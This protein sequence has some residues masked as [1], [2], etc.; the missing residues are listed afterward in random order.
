[1]PPKPT[2][3]SAA[4][5][6]RAGRSD[7]L[8]SSTPT[9]LTPT[10]PF[11][12][13][14]LVTALF[15]FL[16]FFLSHARA[17]DTATI[18]GTVSNRATGNLL[19]GVRVEVSQLG[20]A[21]YTDQTGRYVLA[22]LPAGT[23]E[24]A[25]S[26]LGLD[27]SR[28]SV[29][30]LA[31]GR[32]E[33]NFELT[34]GIYQMDA[35]K[36][37][38][39]REGA[40]AAL[41]AQRNA[42]N[43]KNVVAMDSFGNLPNMS[44][45][46]VVMRLPGTAGFPSDEGLYGNF[47]IRGTNSALNSVTIDGA[48]SPGVSFQRGFGQRLF[49]I[50]GTMFESLEL[51]KGHTPDKGADS[52]SGT[53]NMKTRSPLSM[54]EKRRTTYSVTARW[55]PPFLEQT[56]ERERH[57]AHHLLT[58]A[59]QQIFDVFGGE[60]NLA[61]ALNLFTSEN[62]VSGAST[63]YDYQNTQNP[64]AFIWD[65][66]TRNNYNNRKQDSISLRTDYRWSPKT[67]FWVTL[68]GNNNFE[69]HNRSWEVRAFSDSAAAVP[70]ATTGIVPGAFS[71]Q[72]TVVRPVAGAVIDV[73][74]IG[75]RNFYVRTRQFDFNAEHG[76]RNWQIDY[77]AGIGRTNLNNGD[78]EGGTLT[79]RLAGVGWII[80]RTRSD[81]TP[82]F[83]QNGGPDFLNGA[84]YR[85]TANGLLNVNTQRDQQL[86]QF[87]LNARYQLPVS[88]PNYLKAG[89]SWREQRYG[90]WAKDDHRWSYIG[91]APLPTDPTIGSYH[92]RETGQ[93]LPLWQAT[94]VI[95]RRR[96][97]APAL[98]REDLYY[99][100]SQKFSA[101][102]GLTETAQAAYLMAQGKLGREGWLARSGYLGG[103]RFE[104]T[105]VDTWGWVRSRRL[106][107]AAQ[108]VADPVGAALLDYGNNYRADRRSYRQP[109]PS[110]HAF[111]DV[112][113]NLKFRTAFSTSFGRAGFD[114][115]V[116]AETPQREREHRVGQQSRNSSPD[117]EELGRRPRVLLRA[118]RA[119]LTLVV[120]QGNTRLHHRQ[121]GGARHPE[122]RR[123]WVQ[124]R[125]CRLVRT[126]HDQRRQRDRPGLGVRIPAAVHV[127]ARP[128]EGALRAFQLYVD[129]H[130]RHVQRHDLPDA[131]RN[132]GVHPA[133]GQRAT[134]LEL[135][136]VQH[137]APL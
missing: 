68:L 22:G 1:M 106:T 30:V 81:L 82:R 93:N 37:A 62:V 59:H 2:R 74:N 115:F 36:V 38:G 133:H 58:L 127:S 51:I 113:S 109:F 102:Q 125:I 12:N 67:R 75:P 90:V 108:Q 73:Q 17:A 35:F 137:A 39:E 33:L 46:E 64:Q 96:P 120:P 103:V 104:E 50:T 28:K 32:A 66:R 136:S 52:L 129:H 72:L 31:A 119:G 47:T 135:S 44:A 105:L 10:P 76:Y 27:S 114:T 25:V 83:E 86:R 48:Q 88:A 84:N 126:Q 49:S 61:I 98:W 78:G 89:V 8:R 40:A 26:Y 117:G 15:V 128:V 107:T 42:E 7:D 65:F 13:S 54:R 95:D 79:M 29:P 70:S 131:A 111:H 69:R 24:L 132:P 16:C 100:E 87:R 23:Y 110:V 14:H 118:G 53:I 3:F 57:R 77:A 34:T 116:P 19:E 11:V 122:W 9:I 6:A 91:N 130:A 112:T 85:P 123:Q 97:V 21:A 94:S 56:P 99:H 121:S 92:A 4:N 18:T 60:L 43:L 55:A 124:W 101:T 63:Q 80:D 5:I 45:S 134:G 20:L 41:T 71:S